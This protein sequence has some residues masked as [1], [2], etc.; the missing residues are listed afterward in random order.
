MCNVAI[1][2]PCMSISHS[3]VSF[4]CM[5]SASTCRVGGVSCFARSG[6]ASGDT[7]RLS[8]IWIQGIKLIVESSA[9]G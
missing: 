2:F 8:D 3:Y 5:S 4:L 7:I 1:A 6:I 9:V